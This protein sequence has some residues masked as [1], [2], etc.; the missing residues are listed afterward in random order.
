MSNDLKN[1][2]SHL[3]KDIEQDMLL[4]YLN[5]TLSDQEQHTLEMQLNDDEFMSDAV[6]GLQQMKSTDKVSLAVSQLNA[7]LKKQLLHNKK[8]RNKGSFMQDSWIYFTVILLLILSIIA[9]MVIRKFMQ[10]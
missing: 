4:Q 3:N 2:L 5:R 8:K 1:I 7:G 10:E 6:D 9:F